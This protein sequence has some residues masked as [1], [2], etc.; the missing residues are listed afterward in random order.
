MH[1]CVHARSGGGVGC[2][3]C[4]KLQYF[5]NTPIALPA[6]IHFAQ[7]NGCTKACQFTS[8]KRVDCVVKACKSRGKSICFCS[9]WLRDGCVVSDGKRKKRANE[10]LQSNKERRFGGKKMKPF[11]QGKQVWLRSVS[12]LRRATTSLFY[13]PGFCGSSYPRLL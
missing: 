2:S 3:R 9:G 5:C 1:F 10:N 11:S 12:P 13:H 6:I 4:T 7:A 8:Q